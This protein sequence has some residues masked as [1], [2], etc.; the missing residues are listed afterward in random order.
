M[1]IVHLGLKLRSKN[2]VYI[3]KNN[4]IIIAEL[5]RPHIYLAKNII[6]IA[7]SFLQQTTNWL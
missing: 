5:K 1:W 6:I 4:S 7:L 2:K 3:L